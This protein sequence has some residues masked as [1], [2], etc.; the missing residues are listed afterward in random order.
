MDPQFL[1]TQQIMANAQAIEQNLTFLADLRNPY[2]QRRV[3][4]AYVFAQARQIEDL[5]KSLYNQFRSLEPMY[6]SD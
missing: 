6:V 3:A 1:L 4:Y 2:E 5:V